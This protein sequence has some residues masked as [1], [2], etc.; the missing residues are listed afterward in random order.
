MRF[1]MLPHIG[2]KYDVGRFIRTGHRAEFRY[3]APPE[4]PAMIAAREEVERERA[5][6]EAR[7]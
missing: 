3:Y 4:T 5:M 2:G 6:H 1:S 7:R